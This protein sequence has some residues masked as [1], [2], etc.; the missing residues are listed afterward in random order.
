MTDQE[1]IEFMGWP[2]VRPEWLREGRSSIWGLT[3]LLV[4][5]VQR[6]ESLK[7]DALKAEVLAALQIGLDAAEEVAERYHQEMQ[8]YRP[9]VHAMLDNNVLLIKARIEAL[10]AG[11]P[12]GACALLRPHEPR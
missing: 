5:E 1:I 9:H 11:K 2:S 10:T 7:L 6:R 4:D 3:R 12:A 8:G